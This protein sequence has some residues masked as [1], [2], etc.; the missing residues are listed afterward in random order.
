MTAPNPYEGALAVMRAATATAASTFEEAW[1]SDRLRAT[2]ATRAALDAAGPMPRLTAAE[3]A[4]FAPPDPYAP[5]LAA[6]RE[7]EAR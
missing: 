6:L 7:G 5:G 2:S 3:A 4:E 1:K